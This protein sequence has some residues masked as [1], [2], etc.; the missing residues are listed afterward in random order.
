M[1]E[2]NPVEAAVVAGAPSG[3]APIVEETF[4]PEIRAVAGGIVQRPGRIKKVPAKQLERVLEEVERVGGVA[5]VLEALKIDKRKGAERLVPDYAEPIGTHDENGVA[6]PMEDLI[7]AYLQV[8]PRAGA[9]ALRDLLR[10]LD[11]PRRAELLNGLIKAA[12][13]LG[14]G[15]HI[16]RTC[17][18]E[19][20]K[21]LI[22][23]EIDVA[24]LDG[25]VHDAMI[26]VSLS[27]NLHR[28]QPE[29]L[30]ASLIRGSGN[31]A[32]E[33]IV[34]TLWSEGGAEH[35]EAIAAAWR[36]N[37]FNEMVN[38][39]IVRSLAA[40]G[41]LSDEE[42]AQ[43]AATKFGQSAYQIIAQLPP[44]Q[45]EIVLRHLPEEVSLPD[46][47]DIL[48]SAAARS[49]WALC[50]AVR[51]GRAHDLSRWLRRPGSVAALE[52]GRGEEVMRTILGS[53]D[54]EQ[55]GQLCSSLLSHKFGGEREDIKYLAINV[56]DGTKVLSGSGSLSAYARGHCYEQLGTNRRAWDY[57]KGLIPNWRG[58]IVQLCRAAEKMSRTR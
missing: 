9:S 20:V 15:W 6:V 18:P 34:T 42:I 50:E 8:R 12:S 36:A 57:L 7:L 16:K 29:H 38:N 13:T 3:I 55:I 44:R 10:R 48:E 2:M 49:T 52:N 28:H 46:I 23:G 26:A 40:R 21:F 39:N 25:E 41:V 11:R 24:D 56:P 22:D 43:A 47:S 19:G 30:V 27:G 35:L 14:S 1:R 32:V 33:A 4:W 17:L 58:S 45:G 37:K 54:A 51:R 31:G 5:A 53:W